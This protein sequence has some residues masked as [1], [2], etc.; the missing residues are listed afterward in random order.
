[1]GTLL[2]ELAAIAAESSPVERAMPSSTVKRCSEKIKLLEMSPLCAVVL[3]SD[4][5]AK[6][7]NQLFEQLMGPLFKLANLEFFQLA[8][9][10]DGKAALGAAIAKVRSGASKRERLRNIEMLTVAGRAGLPIKSHFDWYIGPGMAAD[11][12]STGAAL[13][14]VILYGDACS[15]DLLEQ[16]EKDAELIDF[17]Q[18]APIALHWLSGTGHVMW[19]NQTELDVLGYT[20]EEYIGQPIMQFCPDEE[21]LVLEIF[22]TLGSGNI[23]KDV[24]VR[25]RTKAG[26]I[27]PLLIDS[28]VAYKVD[29][30]GE[31]AFNHTRCFIRDDTGRRVREARAETMLKETTR[32]IK[33]LDAFVSR[34]LHLVK[35]PCHVVKASLEVLEGNVQALVTKLPPADALAARGLIGETTALLA[36]SSQQL[37]DIGTLIADASDVIRFDQGAQV[38]TTDAP[39]QLPALCRAIADDAKRLT[40]P[41]VHLAVEVGTGPALVHLDATVLRRSLEHLMRNAAA[42][43]PEGGRITLRVR[44]VGQSASVDGEGFGHRV[45]FEVHDTGC[46]LSPSASPCNIFHRY[47]P[48]SLAG[49]AGS[50]AGG[51]EH[52]PAVIEISPDGTPTTT[53]MASPQSELSAASV[54]GGAATLESAVEGAR[55]GLEK[56]LSLNQ[57]R[58]HAGLGVGLNLTY[59][60]VRALG[61]ELRVES[62]PGNTQFSFVLSGLRCADKAEAESVY[63]AG[64]PQTS[65]EGRDEPPADARAGFAPLAQWAR[66][67]R[68]T[69]QAKPKRSADRAELSPLRF[70][71]EEPISKVVHASSIAGCGLRALEAPHVLVVEDTEMCAMV[72]MM[73]LQKLGCSADHAEDGQQALDM[74]EKAEPGLYS[75]VLM[76]LRMPVMDGFE[77]TSIIKSKLG[78]TIPVVALTAEEAVDTRDKCTATGFDDFAA[79]PLKHDALVALLEKHTGHEVSKCVG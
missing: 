54:T 3:D 31:K 19:A 4:G 52:A 24:P 78:L 64:T 62:A 23:I 72:I 44:H 18:N 50:L 48:G 41:R 45:R 59:S 65:P 12:L 67:G 73:L 30:K 20:A 66:S 57:D 68:V 10:E 2:D 69:K 29:E 37:A 32:S 39:V 1:M 40:K 79:K 63:V 75:L 34:T 43:T 60:L 28:N 13:A 76:D 46:G 70:V 8:S 36:A 71:E 27:V 9:T 33:L 47:A 16:R 35:T 53:P 22:K 55:A 25:F 61:G 58:R 77:A 74:L 49:G 11:P 42:A 5:K 6:E 51:T 14:E 15:D 7:I 38:Q 17:F 56:A 21:E 26:K